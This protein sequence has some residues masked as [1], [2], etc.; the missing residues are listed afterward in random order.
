NL[1]L[2]FEI[3]EFFKL[4]G[5]IFIFVFGLFVGNLSRF[6][7]VKIFRRIHPDRINANFEEFHHIVSEVNFMV[8]SFFFL[9]LGFFINPMQLLSVKSIL[10]AVGILIFAYSI[11]FVFLKIFRIAIFPG[12]FFAPRGLVSILLFMYIPAT[13]LLP[14][15]TLHLVIIVVIL[16]TVIM[17]IGGIIKKQIPQKKEAIIPE[18][19]SSDTMA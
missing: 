4:P 17:A 3:S 1:V 8:R 7:K 14:P 6:S 2:V 18:E 12:L 5:L 11:R 16:S 9:L 13:Q 15:T 10:W 19:R